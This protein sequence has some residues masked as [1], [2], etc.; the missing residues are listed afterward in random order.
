MDHRH[1]LRRLEHQLE[2]AHRAA[3]LISNRTIVDRLEAFAGEISERLRGLRAESLEEERHGLGD[4][5]FGLW[6]GALRAGDVKT[7]PHRQQRT[8]RLS[9]REA[10]PRV[11]PQAHLRN[12]G[13][14]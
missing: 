6:R 9:E 4:E 12:L 2:L 13:T 3:P 11:K 8:D 7:M 14:P 10:V 1:E 5:H